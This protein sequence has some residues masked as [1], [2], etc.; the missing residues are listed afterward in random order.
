MHQ[1]KPFAY[2]GSC[3]TFRCVATMMTV[4]CDWMTDVVVNHLQEQIWF[5]TQEFSDNFQQFIVKNP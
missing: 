1:I 5:T 4:K 2:F 3:W